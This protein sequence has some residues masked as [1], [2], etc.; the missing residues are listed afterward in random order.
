VL[1][2]LLAFLSA[3]AF[4]QRNEIW[5][6]P[7]LSARRVQP[8][9]QQ[10]QLRHDMSHCHGVAFEGTRGADDDEVRKA[11]GV[12]LF[13]RCMAEKGW[14]SRDPAAPRPAPKAPRQTST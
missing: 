3:A 1:P 13:R 2:I 7:G 6:N 9:E 11:R 12:A 4:A 5:S 14:A 8:A 10:I